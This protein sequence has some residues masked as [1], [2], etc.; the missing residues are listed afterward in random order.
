[1]PAKSICP[2]RIVFNN[3]CPLSFVFYINDYINISQVLNFVVV[4]EFS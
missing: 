2:E 3:T 4:K 1:M